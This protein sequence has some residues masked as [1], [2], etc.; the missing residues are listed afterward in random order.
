MPGAVH[1]CDLRGGSTETRFTAERR[2]AGAV[3]V[4]LRNYSTWKPGT[5]V[6]V[7]AAP[8]PVSTGTSLLNSY[9]PSCPSPTQSNSGFRLRKLHGVVQRPE[10]RHQDDRRSDVL[11]A[12]SGRSQRTRRSAKSLSMLKQKRTSGSEQTG[13]RLPAQAARTVTVCAASSIAGTQTA[14]CTSALTGGTLTATVTRSRNRNA[15][16]RLGLR[17]SPPEAATHGLLFHW[18][19]RR[20]CR[21]SRSA[22]RSRPNAAAARSAAATAGPS[23][24]RAW[25]SGSTFG[26]RRGIRN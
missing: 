24:W 10:C 7:P 3:R 6:R 1:L 20:A 17:Q 21:D 19:G 13:C 8:M 18:P 9:Q 2:E 26:S 4:S 16:V 14:G 15:V 12:S 22:F 25:L 5:R 23:S 11:M